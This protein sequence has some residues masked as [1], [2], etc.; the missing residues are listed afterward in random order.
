MKSKEEYAKEY[1]AGV[2][3]YQDRKQYA[4]NDFIAGWD[5]AERWRTDKE[6]IPEREAVLALYRDTPALLWGREVKNHPEIK[7]WKPIPKM[8]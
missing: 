6:D 3:H 4:A 1:A 8:P 5:A 2:P 7:Y